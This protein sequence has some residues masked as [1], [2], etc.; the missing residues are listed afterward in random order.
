MNLPVTFATWD[1]STYYHDDTNTT[2]VEMEV[3]VSHQNLGIIQVIEAPTDDRDRDFIMMHNTCTT[4]LRLEPL[5]T[6][7]SDSEF[8]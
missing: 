1:G 4:S 7:I 5:H 3:E 8:S 6:V 2:R